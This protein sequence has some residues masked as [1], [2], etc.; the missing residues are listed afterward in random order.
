MNTYTGSITTITGPMFGGKTSRLLQEKRKN[1][2][3]QKRTLLIKNPRDV[4]YGNDH[5]VYTHDKEGKE[6]YVSA[7][8]HK[9]MECG[10]TIDQIVGGY[11]VVCVDEGQF[12][13]DVDVFCETLANRGV[14]VY[15][16]TL[17]GDFKRE[18]FPVVA[19]LLALSDDI[20]FTKA[21]DRGLGVD[22]PFTKIKYIPRKDVGFLVG[23]TELYEATSRSSFFREQ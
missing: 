22:A 16:S 20:I 4:R 6:A 17:L 13:E 10:L 5:L 8:D 15:C 14:K 23:S 21:I 19:R 7:S 12:Y 1:E 2:I 3:I 9:L 18:P 11:D